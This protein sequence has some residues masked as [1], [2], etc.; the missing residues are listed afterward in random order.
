MHV[1]RAI[2]HRSSKVRLA[3]LDGSELSRTPREIA[4]ALPGATRAC[5]L[6]GV[7][8]GWRESLC[9]HGT[10]FRRGAR[11]ET[12]HT[13]TINRQRYN[14]QFAVYLAVCSPDR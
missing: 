12:G 9:G 4:A 3:S 10:A 1:C 14:N 5:C 11:D 13:T 8:G 2:L 7:G 6:V